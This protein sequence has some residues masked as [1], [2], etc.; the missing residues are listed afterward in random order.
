MMGKSQ[1]NLLMGETQELYSPDEAVGY[2][3]AGS[4]ALFKGDYK[5]V[6]NF[7]PFGDKKWRLFNI[8]KDPV[9]RYD[10]SSEMPKRFSDMLKDYE[11]YKTKVKMVEVSE[12]YHVIKQLQKNLA[13]YAEDGTVLH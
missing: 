6:R 10:L 4:S 8:V 9:E 2:E 5:L 12:D 13:R 7:P 1:L 3:L 11:D